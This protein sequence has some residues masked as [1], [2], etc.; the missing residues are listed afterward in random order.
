MRRTR[1]LG[2]GLAVAFAVSA[3]AAAS[4][5]AALPEFVGPFPKGFTS[6]SGKVTL[7]T[8]GKTKVTCTGDTNAGQISGPKEGNARIRFTGCIAANKSQC[9]TPGASSGEIVTSVLTVTL[10]Y[11]SRETREAAI[12]FSSPPTGALFTE[13]TCLNIKAN[14][15]GSVIGKITPINKKVKPPN[16]FTVKFKQAKGKQSIKNLAG[17]STDVLETSIN[18][19]PVQETGLGSVDKIS[20]AAETEVKA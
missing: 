7:E 6:V 13:F 11:I 2:L 10:G 16:A 14:V 20:F 1:T 19:G 5:A 3:V 17:A 4:A 15:R 18:G 12:D 9:M 8:V